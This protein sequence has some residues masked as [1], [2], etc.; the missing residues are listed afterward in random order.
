M[1]RAARSAQHDVADDEASR[2]MPPTSHRR[3]QVSAQQQCR[4]QQ[5][6]DVALA[7]CGCVCPRRSAEST[8]RRQGLR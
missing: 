8:R 3:H 5:L 6:Q 1:R 7:F 4:P 2:G